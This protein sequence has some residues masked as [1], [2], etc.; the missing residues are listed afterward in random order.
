MSSVLPPIVAKPQPA[1][2]D[3]AE[4]KPDSAQQLVLGLGFGI[5]FG[6]LLQKGGVAKYEVLMG[7]LLLT[8]FTVFKIMLTAIAVGAVGI[9]GMHALGLVKLHVKK[10][11][12]AANIIGGLT[13]GAGFALL[14][15]CPGTGAA[16]L[17]QGNLD[18]IAG[19]IGMMAGSHLFAEFSH[20]LSRLQTVGSRGGIMLN[21]LVGLPLRVFLPIFVAA[22]ALAL[23]LIERLAG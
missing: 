16:A 14:G 3:K 6:F 20:P 1:A 17:G 19:I 4:S 23:V 21:E 13:F 15:Y 5:V 8:D 22:L 9:F 10:T 7:S 12:Y 18:A 11:Q 2:G